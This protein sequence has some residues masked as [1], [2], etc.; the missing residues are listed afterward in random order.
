MADFFFRPVV[1]V[2]SVDIRADATGLLSMK[3][4]YHTNVKTSYQAWIHGDPDKGRSAVYIGVVFVDKDYPNQWMAIDRSG[5]FWSSFAT[6]RSGAAN[7][8]R[9]RYDA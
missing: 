3:A 9:R 5:V 7:Y 8:L 1:H 4:T 2:Q 6:T